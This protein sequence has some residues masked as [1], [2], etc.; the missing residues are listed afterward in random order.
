MQ[1][2][3]GTSSLAQLISGA[4]GTRP[5]PATGRPQ[6]PQPGSRTAGATGDSRA[7][8]TAPSSTTDAAKMRNMPRGSLVNIVT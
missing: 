7:L 5:D 1:I 2:N 4:A 8:T 3:S 6:T